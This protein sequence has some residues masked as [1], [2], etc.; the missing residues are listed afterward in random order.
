MDLS[1]TLVH[2]LA[3]AAIHGLMAIGISLLWSSI[4][5]IYMAHGASFAVSGYAAWAAAEAAKPLIIAA[6]GKTVIGTATMAGVCLS[7]GALAGAAMGALIFLLAFLPIHD[8]PNYPV[9]SLIATLAINLATVQ[10]LLWYFGPKQKSLPKIFGTGKV[11]ILGLSARYDQIGTIL[12]TAIILG[13]VLFWLR[14]S[15]KGLEIRAMMQNPEGAVLSGIS[16]RWTALPVTMLTGALA[17]TAAVL[18]S[19]MIFVSPTSGAMPLIKGLT[20]ALL[21]GLGSVPGA[22]LGA[23]IIGFLEA[24]I[25]AVPFLGQRYVLFGTFLFIIFVLIIRPRGIGGLLDEAR[26]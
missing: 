24:I 18:L 8:K 25:G 17:G 1:V 9:R 15:R 3:L 10:A 21:G 14:V 20:I 5:M 22:V 16:V 23:E 19:Q 26:K 11:E 12:G 4:G 7:V 6:F 13:L 2:G